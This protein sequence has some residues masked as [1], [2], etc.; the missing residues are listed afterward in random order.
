MVSSVDPTMSARLDCEIILVPNLA[1]TSS[2]CS[3]CRM[4]VSK[5]APLPDLISCAYESPDPLAVE[6]HLKLTHL[7]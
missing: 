2:P 5:L 3:V 4:P 1:G 6:L 7:G